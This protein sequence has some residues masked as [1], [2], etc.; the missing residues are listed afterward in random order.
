MRG[1]KKSDRNLSFKP[2]FKE[3]GPLKGTPKESLTLRHDELEAIYLADHE[4]LYQDA[5]AQRMGVSRTTFS[6]T[7][8]SARHKLA[9]LL[10]FGRK[11][12]I[13]SDDLPYRVAFPALDRSRIADNPILAPF[14]VIAEVRNGRIER[15]QFLDNPVIT[16]LKAAKIALPEG[17]D[18]RGLAAGR[19]IPEILAGVNVGVFICIGDGL[20]RNLEGLGM[21]IHLT[22]QVSID[23]AIKGL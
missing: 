21:G 8:K 5:C 7:I 22:D 18:G 14:Y 19:L 4:G 2:L 12:E 11:I 13:Q 9:A 1:R 20:R 23:E 15:M 6:R 16:E 3:F 10:L 17:H